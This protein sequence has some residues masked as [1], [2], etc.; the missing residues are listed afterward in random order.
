MIGLINDFIL[1]VNNWIM[2]HQSG[3]S[4]VAFSIPCVI[5][6]V[7][8]SSAIRL[9][10]YRKKARKYFEDYQK[11][12]SAFEILD[13]DINYKQLVERII[14]SR[15][16]NKL[17]NR[18]DRLTDELEFVA[19]I[20]AYR[21]H[22]DKYYSLNEVIEFVALKLN[23]ETIDE[24]IDTVLNLNKDLKNAI[25]LLKKDFND[26]NALDLINR[27]TEIV[28]ELNNLKRSKTRQMSQS[29]NTYNQQCDDQTVSSEDSSSNSDNSYFE[30]SS[31]GGG[32][33]GGF[34]GGGSSDSF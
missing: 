17:I 26:Q 12:L 2:S 27:E 29:S 25:E 7:L 18:K 16:E 20:H 11:N 23:I 1:A 15:N 4:L 33:G 22:F 14:E 32:D 21:T 31:W 5:F 6:V 24:S 8:I 10:Y 28:Q 30:S 19:M 13:S 9:R 34:S 3:L